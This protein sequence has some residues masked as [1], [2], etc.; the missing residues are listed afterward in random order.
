MPVATVEK[1]VKRGS[2]RLRRL[3]WTAASLIVLS[4]VATL[5]T[6]RV[7]RDH[8]P[9]EYVPGESS[10]DITDVAADRGNTQQ[11]QPAPVAAKSISSRT[12]D[13]LLQPGKKLPAGAP[14]PLLTDVTKEAGLDS[15]RQFQRPRTSI[16]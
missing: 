12:I 6:W 10:N 5:A 2:K 4:G 1:P 9:E 3:T 15:F 14:E 11:K 16:A 13:P 7:R 8:Q